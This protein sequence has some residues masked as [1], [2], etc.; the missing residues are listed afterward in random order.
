MRFTTL[1][2]LLFNDH[3]MVLSPKIRKLA[4]L[5]GD[6]DI[7]V[8]STSRIHMH[9]TSKSD[10][11]WIGS[12]KRRWI[13]GI[14]EVIQVLAFIIFHTVVLRQQLIVNHLVGFAVVI[15]G[16]I[17]VLFGPFHQTV[18][19]GLPPFPHIRPPPAAMELK[20]EI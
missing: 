5:D 7:V 8:H 1:Y 9:D 17:I 3:S 6:I 10:W 18:V 19:H 12:T 11:V 16:F 20:N 4:I 14:A 13:E 15:V 2:K